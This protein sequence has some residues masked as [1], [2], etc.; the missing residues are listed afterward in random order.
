MKILMICKGEYRYPFP[1]VARTLKTLYGCEM[2]A[3][4]FATPASRMMEASRAFTE[5][6]NIAAHLKQ[7][8]EEHHFE[9]CIQIL[10]KMPSSEM[11]S[12]MIY[13][14]RII[15]QYPFERVIGLMAGIAQFWETLL[16]RSRPDCIVGEVACASE[17]VAYSVAQ[18]LGIAFLIPYVTPLAK[19]VFLT[20]SPE[21]QWEPAAEFYQQL[22]RRGLTAEEECA[23][24]QFL[25]QFRANKSKPPFLMTSLRSPFHVDLEQLK[26][27]LKRIP[28]RI[29]TW[30][31]D[32]YFEVGSYHGTPPWKPVW[33]DITKGFRHLDAEF[34]Y[35][36]HKIPQCRKV[37]FPLHVQP[38]YTTDVRAP[39]YTN[40]PAVVENIAKSTPAGYR[41]MVKEHP[42]MKGL[43]APGYYRSLRDL[44]NVDL[45]S[46]S[47]EGHELVLSSDVI[48]TITGTTAW[49]SILYEKP[50]IALG[51][52]C[53]DYCDLVYRCRNITDLPE[54]IREALTGFRPDHNAVLK[55]IWSILATAYTFD[56][57]S[58][59]SNPGMLAHDNLERIAAAII[60]S[61]PPH[62]ALSTYASLA[63]A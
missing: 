24:E 37:Y 53:Y 39:F 22:K 14:D 61:I 44:Y 21:G 63:P 4:T 28:F 34:R 6:H 10:D 5:V 7:F 23:A 62:K 30:I 33:I 54:L 17:W 27:R 11:V 45:L 31:E 59:I 52:L 15:L 18:S 3:M 26:K 42:G 19:R 16:E 57:G 29:Q 9:E 40:Q 12:R 1:D 48:V 2:I 43:R 50:V 47:V 38:E 60:A 55:F 13:A 25:R 56:W 46:P 20:H 36:G 32:G 8:V 41:V 51:P 35:F 58:G 49:E